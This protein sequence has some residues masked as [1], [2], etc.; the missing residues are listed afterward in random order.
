MG[1]TD[2]DLGK[3]EAESGLLQ[4]RS[5]GPDG[6]RT[7]LNPVGWELNGTRLNVVHK[8]FDEIS[9]SFTVEYSHSSF[10]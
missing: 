10:L 4:S 1:E 2:K 8:R 7:D 5:A 6:L 3:H 9:F